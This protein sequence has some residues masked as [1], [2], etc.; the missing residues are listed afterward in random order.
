MNT[1]ASPIA[2]PA[3]NV[4]VSEAVSQ[5]SVIPA[6]R[7]KKMLVMA[8]TVLASLREAAGLTCNRCRRNEQINVA[9]YQAVASA[10]EIIKHMATED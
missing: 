2:T 9:L 5:P 8:E 3:K 10:E 6:E 4:P 7:R 1:P